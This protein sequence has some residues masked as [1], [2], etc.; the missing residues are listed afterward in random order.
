MNVKEICGFVTVEKQNALTSIILYKT[1][2]VGKV[3]DGK[4]EGDIVY[5]KIF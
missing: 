4:L 5:K 2:F 3:L 1:V